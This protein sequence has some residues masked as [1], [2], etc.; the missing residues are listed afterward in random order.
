MTQPHISVLIITY[1]HRAFIRQTVES[2]LQQDFDSFEVVVADDGS[3]DGADQIILQLAQEHPG[4]VVPVVGG[5]N[6]GIAKNSNRGLK[7]C[8]GRFFNLLGGDDLFLPGKLRRQ[9]DWFEADSR[10][11]LC[12]HDAYVF[13]SATDQNTR[14]YSDLSEWREGVGAEAFLA[15]G[16]PYLPSAVMVRASELPSYGFDERVGLVIDGKLF[17]DVLVAGGRYGHIDGVYARYRRH[18]GNMTGYASQRI[19][20]DTFTYLALIEAEHPRLVRACRMGRARLHVGAGVVALKAGKSAEA[21]THF[22]NALLTC[23]EY[24]WKV[25]AWYALSA[26]PSRL[27]DVAVAHGRR[28]VEIS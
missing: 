23:P 7:L 19:L 25:P 15:K 14:R 10:R 4:K 6:V 8:R 20:T 5:P 26:L 22:T 27:R 3:T 21:R 12:G 24:S 18:G 9:A 11:V 1:N 16:C 2:V 28:K 13:E 17:I